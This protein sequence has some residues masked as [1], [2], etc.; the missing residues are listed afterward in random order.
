MKT[1]KSTYGFRIEKSSRHGLFIGTLAVIA[2][3]FIDC[4][5]GY[6]FGFYLFYM[7]PIFFVAWNADLKYG[8]SISIIAAI[9]WFAADLLAKEFQVQHFI[10]LWNSAIRLITFL[11]IAY[12][13]YVIRIGKKKNTELVEFIIHDLRTPVT[14]IKESLALIKETSLEKLGEEGKEFLEMGT[15]SCERLKIL[16]DTILD[17][18]R[19]ES[20]KMPL[21]FKDENIKELIESSLKMVSVLA[22]TNNINLHMQYDADTEVI[23]TDRSLLFRILINLLTNAIKVSNANSIVSV[24]AFLPNTQ[25]VAISVADQGRGIPK[26]MV[27]KMFNKFTQIKARESGIN[28]G[29]GLGLN[30]CK[31][32]VK[33]LRGHIRLESKEGQ[34]TKVTFTLPVK[35]KK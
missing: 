15:I 19:L 21:E 14:V 34:G 30:F 23:S 11:I 10:I 33:S 35:G 24:R 17:L 1:F 12:S 13:T 31:L 22:K 6:K 25:C 5:T 32:A 7:I 27:R 2:V 4:L 3:G 18:S 28:F 26:A 20:E 29:S 16:I 8:I 9:T